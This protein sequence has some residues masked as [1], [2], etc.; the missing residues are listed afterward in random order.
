MP[1]AMVPP[2]GVPAANASSMWMGLESPD[3]SAYSL[4]F[5]WLTAF[6][7]GDSSG[8][9]AFILAGR[10]HQGAARREE[11]AAP[12]A[13][14]KVDGPDYPAGPLRL[15]SDLGPDSNR[16]AQPQPAATPPLLG[17]GEGARPRAP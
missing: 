9:G 17:G 7:V 2:R 3:A 12:I 4:I 10:C 11:D 6:T 16:L 14:F 15:L 1:W 8:V 5:A 13:G